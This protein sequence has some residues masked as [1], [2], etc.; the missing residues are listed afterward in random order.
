MNDSQRVI[1]VNNFPCLSRFGND[2]S[3]IANIPV[4]TFIFSITNI[5][6]SA[7]TINLFNVYVGQFKDKDSFKR[8][9]NLI[10]GHLPFFLLQISFRITSFTLILVYLDT[11]AAAFLIAMWLC[12]LIIGYVT[13]AAHNLG[14]EMRTRLQR[15]RSVARLEANQPK[16]EVK[17]AERDTQ[18]TPIW[19]NSF[20]SLF[21]PSCYMRTVDPAIFNIDKNQSDEQKEKDRKLRKRFFEKEKQFQRKVIRLQVLSSTTILLAATGL[22]FFLVQFGNWGYNNNILDNYAFQ[23]ACATTA[24]LG[25]FSFISIGFIDIYELFGLNKWEKEVKENQKKGSRACQKTLLTIIFGLL[26]VAPLVAGFVFVSNTSQRTGYLSLKDYNS[27]HVKIS[28]ISAN[29]LT[30]SGDGAV[31]LKEKH[32]TM[33][34]NATEVADI[35]K[36]QEK[37]NNILVIDFNEK[38]K[39]EQFIHQEADKEDSDCLKFSSIVFLESKDFKSS[40]PKQNKI[41]HVPVLSVHT[42]DTELI[43]N[44]FTKSQDV[45]MDIFYESLDTMMASLNGDSDLKRRGCN[46][47]TNKQTQSAPIA[48]NKDAAEQGKLYVGGEKVND[49]GKQVANVKVNSE[50]VLTCKIYGRDCSALQVWVQQ[51]KNKEQMKKFEVECQSP[52]EMNK[53]NFKEQIDEFTN[54]NGYSD[55]THRCFQKNESTVIYSRNQNSNNCPIGVEDRANCIWGDW[56]LPPPLQGTPTA[57]KCAGETPRGR[58]SF[59][60]CRMKGEDLKNCLFMEVRAQFFKP[61][62]QK[63]DQSRGN[64]CTES[65]LFEFAECPTRGVL[66]SREGKEECQ[67]DWSK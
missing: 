20:L 67:Y 11:W 14:S 43:K 63:C 3:F 47:L 5:L 37:Q 40:S 54:L 66:P 38:E 24:L 65:N 41:K 53:K 15:A 2:I 4:L 12:N 39:C 52:I 25:I 33:C 30:S 26:A 29:R 49:E 60:F 55:E 57:L 32:I 9:F 36:V 34:N 21:V 62:T 1:Y 18:D 48:L 46:D 61:S 50:L 22:M 64:K 44:A 6:S 45:K 42:R 7:F 8:Y 10:G 56:I 19:L 51:P 13:S 58:Q 16:I 27:T 28:L 31:D 59:R 23:I 35:C 17:G